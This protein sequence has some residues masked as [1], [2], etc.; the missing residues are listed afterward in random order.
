MKIITTVGTSIFENF[1][2]DKIN[3]NDNAFQTHFEKVRDD[4]S[5]Y[6]KWDQC[7]SRREHLEGK[8]QNWYSQKADAS[9]EIASILKIVGLDKPEELQEKVEIILLA[10]DTVLSKL[11]CDLIYE[12][13]SPYENF[14][15]PECEI[16]NKN[17]TVDGKGFVIENLR[18]SKNEDYEQ[19]FMRLIEVL[20]D[21]DLKPT[22]VLN[23]TG[24]YKAIIPILTIYG[25]LKN[26]PLKYIYNEQE[27]G[28]T[29]LIKLSGDLPIGFDWLKTELYGHLLNSDA[30]NMYDTNSLEYD[31]LEK[32]K[33]VKKATVKKK[34][35]V[36]LSFLGEMLKKY[37]ERES[38]K[39][40][41]IIGDFAEYKILEYFMNYPFEESYTQVQK[42][43][44]HYLSKEQSEAYE[45]KPEILHQGEYEEI[46]IDLLLIN[47]INCDYVIV[48]SKFFNKVKDLTEKA[49]KRIIT[50]KLLRGKI[51]KNYILYI[52]KL[53]TQRLESK[54]KL[55]DLQEKC[56]KYG[57]Q[58]I[59]YFTDI[60]LDR[61]KVTINYGA[62]IKDRFEPENQI[63]TYNLNE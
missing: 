29:D 34:I 24:G 21:L 10:T 9:A 50:E 15:F 49:E 41:N 36:T 26:I 46:E 6:D 33:I 13:F 4:F 32:L 63:K 17:Y 48:E 52:P 2:K 28:E 51:A 35:K 61:E 60:E 54:K 25:Q 16:K 45:F 62:F 40:P 53:S 18:I 20:D 22:D 23:I 1:R 42:G 30:L 19:G 57:V 58:L 59:I 11:A 44:K 38:P 37:L 5:T 55:M 39:S 7:K 14:Q 12:W 56:R 8:I 27:L 31:E 3:K 43:V 47:P